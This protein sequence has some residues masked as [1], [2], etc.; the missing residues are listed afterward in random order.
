[1]TTMDI[2]ETRLSRAR[3]ALHRQDRPTAIRELLA[4]ASD[5]HAFAAEF[6]GDPHKLI[7]LDLRFNDLCRACATL[8]TGE[9]T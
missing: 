9:Q 6:A 8:S 3:I 1:M 2:L 4:Y 5:A 7:T